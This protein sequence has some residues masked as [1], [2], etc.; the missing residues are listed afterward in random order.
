MKTLK[1]FL[2]ESEE[3]K[4]EHQAPG[5]DSGAPMHDVT[6][7]GVYPSDFYSNNGFKYYSDYGNEYDK[8]NHD[9]IVRF[10]DKPDEK[11]AIHRAVPVEVYNKA[12]KSDN[13]LREMIRPGDWVTTSKAYAKEHGEANLSGKY[14]IATMRVPAKHLHTNG[15]SH[16]EWGYN[17]EEIKESWR[18]LEA[19]QQSREFSREFDTRGGEIASQLIHDKTAKFLHPA[20]RKAMQN[21]VNRPD[22]IR[23]Q[24]K[25]PRELYG[26]DT[27]KQ[28]NVQN[29]TGTEDWDTAK[30]QLTPERV[31]RAEKS[32]SKVQTSPTI[33]RV[34][35][36]LSGKTIEHN[37][38]G[39]TR[40]TSMNRRGRTAAVH[41]IKGTVKEAYGKS[42]VS[43]LAKIEKALGR[44]LI[45]SDEFRKKMKEL[46]DRYEEIKKNDRKD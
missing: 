42:Y 35:D 32:R 31:A 15:D 21:L 11:V 10:R 23:K 14:K 13:P 27:L 17:P 20:I 34:K 4:G 40:L 26:K 24:L 9:K 25:K 8:E 22:M 2:K 5:P 37:V 6:S 43:P 30:S 39:N 46:N 7:N 44:K 41:V 16:L 38:G 1:Q 3:Y 33:L 45:D 36:P 19:P 28:R 18:S 12:L 29:T